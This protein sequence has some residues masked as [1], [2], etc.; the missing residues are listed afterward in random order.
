MPLHK[1]Y[2]VFVRGANPLL[3]KNEIIDE[4]AQDH[5]LRAQLS[6]MLPIFMKRA[7]FR[8]AARSSA[9]WGRNFMTI[10]RGMLR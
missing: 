10:E 1:C 6:S 5:I 2:V 4:A 7:N 3:F 9:A 8:T